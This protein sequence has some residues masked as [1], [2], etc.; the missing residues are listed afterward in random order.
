MKSV[1]IVIL[2]TIIVVF[3]IFFPVIV[4]K[5]KPGTRGTAPTAPST[6][7]TVSNQN[8]WPMFRG[9]QGLLGRASGTLPDTLELAWKFKTERAIKSSPVIYGDLVFVGSNDDNVYAIDLEKGN[10]V[11]AY[12]TGD[13]VEVISCPE[14]LGY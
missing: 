11:W 5:T 13:A 1:D 7:T 10:H 4:N 6:V 9:S 8:D 14:G 12:K 3:V 2:I